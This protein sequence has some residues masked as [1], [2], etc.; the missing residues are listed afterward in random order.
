M[1][2]STKGPPALRGPDMMHKVLRG[3]G[4]NTGQIPIRLNP[5]DPFANIVII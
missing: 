2:Y 1:V 5:R 4:S 3:S